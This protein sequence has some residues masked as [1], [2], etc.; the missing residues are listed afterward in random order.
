MEE[1]EATFP[2]ALQY[3]Y[4]Y[5]SGHLAAKFTALV[6]KKILRSNFSLQHSNSA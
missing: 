4:I 3:V 1:G 6:E 2:Y 5:T